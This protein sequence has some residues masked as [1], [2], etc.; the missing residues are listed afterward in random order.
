M[1]NLTSMFDEQSELFYS[2]L[3]GTAEEKIILYISLFLTSVI[4]PILSLGIVIFEMFGGDSQKRTIVNMLLSAV[5][6][7]V[8][9]MGVIM[10]I[11]RVTRD[12]LGLLDLQY[13]VIVILLMQ[14]VFKF[15]IFFLYTLLTITRYL[16]IVV[17]KRM[18]GVEDKFWCAILTSSSY[19]IS[20]WLVCCGIC[21][22][23]DPQMT[24]FIK[25]YKEFKQ[26]ETILWR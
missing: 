7:N 15:S 20:L 11:L 8:A 24:H 23:V 14:K 3:Y 25:L 19:L 4:G 9:I 22:G 26:N 18:R 6:W 16:F 12:I 1:S 17:W 10:G 2:H 13:V 21:S 5:L